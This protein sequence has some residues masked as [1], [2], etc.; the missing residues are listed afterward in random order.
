MKKYTL[1]DF[2]AN[3]CTD[4]N[5]Y[6]KWTEDAGGGSYIFINVFNEACFKDILEVESI[7]YVLDQSDDAYVANAMGDSGYPIS[8]LISHKPPIKLEFLS[9]R[10]AKREIFIAS[11]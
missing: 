8:V 9:A 3:I 2:K 5:I 4:G 11:I 6:V 1:E 7:F 10:D